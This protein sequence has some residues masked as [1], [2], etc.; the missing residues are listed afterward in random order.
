M[1]ALAAG[2]ILSVLS[3]ARNQSH[4]R[5]DSV[6]SAVGSTPVI[7]LERTAC[8]GSCPVYSISVN[9]AGQVQ[10]E[11]KAHVRKRGA[12]SGKVPAEQVAAL[13]SDLERNGYFTFAHRYISGEPSCGR[14]ATDSPSAITSATFRGRTRQITHDYGCAAAPGMLVILERKIDEVLGSAQ[15]TGR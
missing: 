8:F 12:A 5:P 6:S 13:L 2:L 1:R 3:C 14:Y 7:T 10:Y 9:S 4:P 15:W 11:G